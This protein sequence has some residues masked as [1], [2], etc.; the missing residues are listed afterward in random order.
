VQF[1][2]LRVVEVAGSDAG[3]YCAKLFADL[4]AGVVRVEGAGLEQDVAWRWLNTSKEIFEC[5]TPPSAFEGLDALLSA[6]DLLIESSSPGPLVALN[7]DR[8]F[9]SLV[10]VQVSPFGSS[11]PYAGY[12]SNAF[13]DEAIGGHLY[14]NGEPAREPIRRPGRHALIQAGTQAFIGAMAALFA[15]QRIGVGQTVEL[16]HFEAF[17]SIH[18][19]TTSMWMNGGFILKREGNRQPGPFHPIGVYPCKDGFV[20]LSLPGSAMVDPFLAAAGLSHLL[21][22]PRF[23]GD[24]ER[25]THKAEFDEA[26]RPWLLE[27]T[28]DEIVEL[29]QAVLTPVGPVPGLLEVASDQHLESRGFWV[30]VPGTPPLRV[31]RGPFRVAGHAFEPRPARRA[32]APPKWVPRDPPATALVPADEPPCGP[33]AGVRILDLTRVWAGPLGGRILAD[34]GAEV[35]LVERPNGRGSRHVPPIAAQITHLYPDNDV[36]EQPWNRISGLNKLMRNRRGI[37]LD[38]RDE[39][40]RGLFQNLVRWAD[41]V[42]ENFSPRAMEQL[43]FGDDELLRLNPHIIHASMPGFG[44]SGPR[45]NWVAFGPLIEA[46]SGLSSIMGYADTGPYRSGVAFPDPVAGINAAAA[47]LVALWDREADPDRRGRPVET[48]MIEAMVSLIGGEVVEAEAAGAD[49]PRRGNR[50]PRWAPNG[51]YPCTGDDRWIAISV[52]ADEEWRALGAFAGLPG[53]WLGWD[54]A[55]RAAQHDA[56][57]WRLAAWTRAYDPRTLMHELQ[58][59]GVIATV[60]SDGR[61]LVEDAHLAA[62]GFW[63]RLD[64]PEVGLRAYPGAP[65]RLSRTPVTYRTPAPT[66]GQHNDEVLGEMGATPLLLATLRARRAIVE[67]P[68]E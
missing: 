14:L 59:L 1:Q 24:F 57:D 15:R 61:D 25:A 45:R 63:A 44:A 17:A 35:I 23:S 4:G 6:A 13:T 19:H 3:A 12:R 5:A 29:G 51:C 58:A 65:L 46:A 26:L 16:S 22:D 48:S 33:L 62:R 53:E 39:D 7:L 50:D 42:L 10:R 67:E 21:E 8:D 18:Q 30:D 27:H 11:G 64:H 34:L 32:T 56:I 41:V 36:G 2:D 55:E 37:T 54:H 68:P 49:P 31:P 40:C 60:V 43:G 38:L 28:A 20:H 47:V 52:T 9:P 66:F